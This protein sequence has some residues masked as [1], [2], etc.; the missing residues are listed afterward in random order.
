[1]NI[2]VFEK[3]K[4]GLIAH[5]KAIEFNYEEGMSMYNFL[6]SDD[7]YKRSLSTNKD[8]LLWV[9]LQKDELRF[10]LEN[11]LDGFLLN[12]KNIVRQGRKL[13]KRNN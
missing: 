6:A 7:R 1:M 12:C 11:A 2:T 5:H 9:S 4:P 10:R 13:Y 8:E 3:L